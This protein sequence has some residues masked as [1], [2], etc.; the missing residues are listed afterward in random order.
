MVRTRLFPFSSNSPT[1]NLMRSFTVWT[2]KKW[3]L[4]LINIRI[5]FTAKTIDC[6]IKKCVAPNTISLIGMTT[7]MEKPRRVME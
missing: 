5:Y 6:V 1:S 4:L 7:S 3:R 2:P